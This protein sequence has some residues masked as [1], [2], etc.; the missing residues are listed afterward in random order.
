MGLLKPP[1]RY[2]H[3][4]WSRGGALLWLLEKG[5]K[6]SPIASGRSAIEKW[7]KEYARIPDGCLT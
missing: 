1:W 7:L 3:R 4:S 2:I 6:I 5:I